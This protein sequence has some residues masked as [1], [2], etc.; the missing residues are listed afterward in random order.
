M[1]EFK[2]L[3][4]K[5][6]ELSEIDRTGVT[7]IK[8]GWW[9]RLGWENKRPKFQKVIW[10]KN[11]GG[12]HIQSYLKAVSIAKEKRPQFKTSFRQPTN[13]IKGVA[14]SKQKSKAKSPD[15][16]PLFY[17]C[18]KYAYVEDNKPKGKTFSFWKTGQIYESYLQMIRFASCFDESIDL[19]RI[20]EY[21]FSY[22]D[23]ADEKVLN[24]ILANS[25]IKSTQTESDRFI[26][27]NR[28]LK[29]TI[30]AVG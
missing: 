23:G 3:R 9:I 15:G 11:F 17:Y 27:K 2:R 16:G 14:L 26:L 6:K 22:L 24:Q 1:T 18:W 20:D 5:N 28:Y 8:D 19:S 13:L 30:P 29:D 12:D 25:D 7:R 21:F 4:K 10:D